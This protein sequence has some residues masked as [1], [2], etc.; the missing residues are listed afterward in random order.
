M[1]GREGG[2]KGEGGGIRGEIW[3]DNGVKEEEGEG[4]KREGGGIRR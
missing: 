3:K 1:K 4:G 2:R